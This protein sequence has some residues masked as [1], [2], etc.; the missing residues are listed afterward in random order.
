MP[1]AACGIVKAYAGRRAMDSARWQTVWDLFHAALERPDG[2]RRDWL[3][4]ATGDD[5]VL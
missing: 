5:D 1:S 3:R 2:E 4:G